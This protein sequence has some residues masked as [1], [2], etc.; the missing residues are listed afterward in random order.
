MKNLIEIN[1]R[2]NVLKANKT[3][4]QKKGSSIYYLPIISKFI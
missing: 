3:G 2:E 1:L 4:Y